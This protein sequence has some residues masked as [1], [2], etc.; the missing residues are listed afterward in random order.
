MSQSSVTRREAITIATAGLLAG[1]AGTAAPAT[2][3]AASND[4]LRRNFADPIWN[5]ETSARLQGNTDAK[6]FVYGYA[7]GVLNAVIEGEKVRPVLRFDVF[8]ATRVIRQPDASYQRLSREVVF[9]RDVDSRKILERWTNPY[10]QEEVK[11]VDVANDPFN[12]VISDHFP[13]P[14]SYGGLNKEKPPRRPYLLNW[15]LFGEDIVTLEA[16]INLLYP[17]ALQPDKWP[18]ESP[19]RM[20]QVSEYFRYFI[21]RDQLT[22]PRLTHLPSVGSWVRVTPWLPWMLMDQKPGHMLYVGDM[23]SLTTLDTV[24]ADV[25][26]RV[27]ERYPQYLTAP[28]VWVEPS[29]SSLEHYAREQKPAPAKPAAPATP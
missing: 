6:K 3:A 12:Y 4:V 1:G 29:L 21:R 11:V 13:D 9:Y 26:E 14:P 17:S 2:A 23:A 25:L 27:K 7:S 18:R 15:G 5:R 16:D 10:T 19:G 20:S 8:S 22:N 24:P 28:E